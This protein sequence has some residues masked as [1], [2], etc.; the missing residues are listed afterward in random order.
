[1]NPKS[2][3]PTPP[4]PSAAKALDEAGVHLAPGE[5]VEY[6][7]VD[8][9]GKKRPEKARPIALY[10]FEDGYDIEFYSRLALKAVETLLLPFGYPAER[11]ARFFNI[12]DGRRKRA[13]R[14]ETDGTQLSLFDVQEDISNNAA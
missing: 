10:A 7:I 8:A 11:L 14:P 1:M 6:I 2:T 13:V 4:A 5:M 12:S 9:T 3:P